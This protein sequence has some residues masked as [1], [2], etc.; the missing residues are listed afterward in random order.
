MFYRNASSDA[1]LGYKRYPQTYQLPKTR[2]MTS[3]SRRRN[4]RLFQKYFQCLVFH[5]CSLHSK[6]TSVGIRSQ[7]SGRVEAFLL[8]LFVAHDLVLQSAVSGLT[9]PLS[10]SLSQSGLTF[11]GQ[12]SNA[13]GDQQQHGDHH[14]SGTAEPARA[15]VRP[16]PRPRPGSRSSR[17]GVYVVS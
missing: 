6:S 17:A 5:Q 10:P 13:E 15:R 9:C 3:T 12:N 14:Q 16:R 8:L 4:G 7:P 1:C 11:T 2:P